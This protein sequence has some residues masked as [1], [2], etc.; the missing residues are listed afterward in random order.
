MFLNDEYQAKVLHI[1]GIL[2]DGYNPFSHDRWSNN[3]WGEKKRAIFDWENPSD[4]GGGSTCL[5]SYI[6]FGDQELCDSKTYLHRARSL[7]EYMNLRFNSR[8]FGKMEEEE[9]KSGFLFWKSVRFHEQKFLESERGSKLAKFFREKK[10]EVIIGSSYCNTSD[11]EIDVKRE[12]LAFTQAFSDSIKNMVERLPS[13]D[14]SGKEKLFKTFVEKYGTHFISRAKMGAMIRF[15]SLFTSRTNGEE[16]ERMRLKCIAE[17]LTEGE[18]DEFGLE[19]IELSIGVDPFD[20]GPHA[21]I[22]FDLASMSDEETFAKQLKNC[23][24]DQSGEKYLQ[25]IGLGRKHVTSI[26][27]APSANWGNQKFNPEPLWYTVRPI[28]ILFKYGPL[29][30]V[31]KTQNLVQFFVDMT[32]NYCKVMLRKP[33]CPFMYGGM[34]GYADN[35]TKNEDCFEADTSFI[36]RGM[37]NNLT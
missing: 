17:S 23:H 34:C 1:M 14:I 35:C 30:E 36:C 3:Q 29:A 6:K 13:L 16:E 28:S 27:S 19:D 5:S 12:T 26:G 25:E 7:K 32:K 8:D 20:L 31:A 9:E 15:E 22:K 2:E 24:K 33:K 37:L 10:G 4:A 11:I 21:K 18:G